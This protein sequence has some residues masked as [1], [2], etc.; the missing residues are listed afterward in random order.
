MVISSD[1]S[2]LT[3]LHA[4]ILFVLVRGTV[5]RGSKRLIRRMLDSEVCREVGCWRAS[6]A[7]EI[8]ELG[9]RGGSHDGIQ[10]TGEYRLL[11]IESMKLYTFSRRLIHRPVIPR[12]QPDNQA[13]QGVHDPASF[14]SSV[15]LSS[16]R[17]HHTRI[18]LC[19]HLVFS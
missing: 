6:K 4:C 3:L 2:D 17:P 8:A 14:P 10:S 13:S 1:T 19:G 15:L 16:I 18:H 7:I 9:Y 5:L 12:N 11:L